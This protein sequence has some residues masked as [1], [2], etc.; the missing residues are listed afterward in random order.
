MSCATTLA[1]NGKTSKS[2][3]FLVGPNKSTPQFVDT[4]CD[5]PC[6]TYCVRAYPHERWFLVQVAINFHKHTAKHCSIQH[7]ECRN[8]QKHC[9][10]GPPPTMRVNTGTK[11]EWSKRK[12]GANE[13]KSVC[14]AHSFLGSEK[15]E[16]KA[17][18]ECCA[19]GFACFSPA[20]FCS[21]TKSGR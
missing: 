10:H 11:Q 16:K 5:A 4:R 18:T 13:P 20:A 7:K 6:Y 19:C 15:K 3:H 8:S 12:W 2:I 1:D 9:N 14:F 21:P 17:L